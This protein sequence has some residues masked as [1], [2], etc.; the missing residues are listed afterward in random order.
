MLKIVGVDESVYK[1]ITC[2]NCA[3]IVQYTESD[4]S[5]KVCG[6]DYSGGSDGHE[7]FNCPSCGSLIKTK[8]W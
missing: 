6:K 7:G 5:V 4:I 2:Y 3:S 1:R 8:V